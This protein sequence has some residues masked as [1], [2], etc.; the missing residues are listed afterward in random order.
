[1]ARECFVSHGRRL[2]ERL[3]ELQEVAPLIAQLGFDPSGWDSFYC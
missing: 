1:M 3:Y 2:E